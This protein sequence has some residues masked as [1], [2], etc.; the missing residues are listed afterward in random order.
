MSAQQYHQSVGGGGY[1][2]DMSLQMHG[3][4][5]GGGEGYMYA[6]QVRPRDDDDA[7]RR[8]WNGICGRNEA[9]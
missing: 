4:E 7:K 5:M 1:E 9:Y 6:G 2:Q 3:M 8:A